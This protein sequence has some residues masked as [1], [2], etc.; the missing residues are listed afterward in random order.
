MIKEQS[1]RVLLC[2]THL[3]LLGEAFELGE[4]LR[5]ATYFRAI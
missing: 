3:P 4:T 2:K 1:L 5:H